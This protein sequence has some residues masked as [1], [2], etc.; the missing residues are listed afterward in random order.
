MGINLRRETRVTAFLS[1]KCCLIKNV[2]W[3][4][5]ILFILHS[6]ELAAI[7]DEPNILAKSVNRNEITAIN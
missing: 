5:T 7:H 1:K 3:N 4:V 6:F 2:S